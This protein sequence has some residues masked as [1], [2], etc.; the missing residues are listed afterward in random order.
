MTIMD[1]QQILKWLGA[2]PG[3]IPAN[4]RLKRSLVE[5]MKDTPV[6]DDA[7]PATAIRA[8]E[9]FLACAGPPGPGR[10]VEPIPQEEG[11]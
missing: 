6:P 2:Q 8:F 9:D 10:L 1:E 5:G 7:D 4:C 3:M 11:P